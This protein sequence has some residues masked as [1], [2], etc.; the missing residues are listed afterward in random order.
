[1][2]ELELRQ[3]FIKTAESYLG[4]NESDESHKQII[5]LYNTINPL[6]S[7]YKVTY[8][9]AWC[10]AYVS[11]M[12]KKANL[13]DIVFPEC[14]CDRMMNLYV[15]A[16]RW[17]ESDSYTP[18]PG[19]I[20]FYDWDDSGIGDNNGSTDHVGIV[21]SVVNNKMKIIEGNT[22]DSVKYKERDIDRKN[23]R[24]FGLP[25]FASKAT[26]PT[27]ANSSVFG[28][29]KTGADLAK[30]AV[31]IAKNYKTLYVNGCFG[32]PMTD[33]NKE[34]YCNNTA[35][36]KKPERT[37]MIMAASSDTFGFDCINL[38]KGLLWGW[39][40]DLNHVYGGA[41]YQSNGVADITEE[42]ML[43]KCFEISDNFNVIEVGEYLWKQGH[44]GIYIGDGLAVECSP[45]W[46]NK[47]QIT[48]CNQDKAGYN[49]RNWTKH[50]KLP[51]VTY[52]S[53]NSAYT[54][55]QFVK[56]VQKILNLPQ[57][58]VA[59][60][61]LIEAT[62]TISQQ[63]NKKHALV[64]PIQKQL[65]QLGFTV[66]GE[67]DG[68][69]GPLFTKAVKEYQAAGTGRIDGE[70][71]AKQKT[72][73]RLLGYSNSS[74]DNVASQNSA[75]ELGDTV[76]LKK[77]S[78]YTNGKIPLSWVYD[79]KLY[80]RE[81]RTND[82]AVVSTQKSG[83]ITGV[84]YLKDLIPYSTYEVSVLANLLNVR[85][86]PNAKSAIVNQ[87]KKDTKVLIYEE[88]DGWGH[89]VNSGWINLKYTKKV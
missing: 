26:Q 27:T 11:A 19:D 41:I 88:Q 33:K 65:Y 20:I 52:S 49:R 69:A 31:E 37:E 4:C 54:Q 61:E 40:G 55:K 42:S 47:V 64:K 86:A 8:K 35:Y 59:D 53:S 1:M 82:S 23:I 24:G 79:T 80:I 2:T 36:N 6:P 21:V 81:F 56:D 12:A 57:T 60:K 15:K 30:A 17:M 78:K 38:I 83:P 72:W 73:K 25:N 74:E 43:E 67:A 14:N 75:Y 87:I 46:A 58:G 76:R 16:D 45:K 66:V 84:V 70:I 39:K 5:D 77:N 9:D 32:A 51:Y 22:S 10:A 89:I 68:S 48:A 71:T 3:K 85:N 34:R 7:G 63:V 50:G 18:N 28:N 44:A 29:I 13:T 62:I